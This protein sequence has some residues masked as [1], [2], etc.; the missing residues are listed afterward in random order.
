MIYIA[1]ENG[2]K[3]EIDYAAHTLYNL[4]DS[5]YH[6]EYYFKDNQLRKGSTALTEDDFLRII[7]DISGSSTIDFT[8]F[9]HDTRM[10][11]SIKNTD[12]SY[13]IGSRASPEVIENVLNDGLEYCYSNIM[14]NGKN[15][16][17]YYIPIMNSSAEAVGMIFAGKPLDSAADNALTMIICFLSICLGIMVISIIICSVY[18]RRIVYAL[19]DI[20]HYMEKISECDF[21]SELSSASLERSDEIG[22]IAQHA[23]KL[24]ISL[25]DLIERDPLTGL[26]NRRSC[27]RKMDE[28]R[29]NGTPFIVIMGDI[30]HFKKINDTY[31]HASGDAVLV[32]VSS[33]ISA[34]ASDAEGFAARWGGEEFLMIYP[35]MRL[36]DAHK[37]LEALLNDIRSER[38]SSDDSVFSITM[39]FGAAETA[40]GEALEETIKHADSLL[41][42]GK[43]S[44]RNMIVIDD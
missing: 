43:N 7:H 23:R 13:A 44:G 24:C 25:R 41:Y 11:T 36:D 19:Y 16:I 10:L 6:G 37:K 29:Q 30:D 21:S 2:V 15:Y 28:L 17:G 8:I 3:K 4:Y 33:I 20:R 27:R 9:W 22:D 42:K 5:N 35:Q 18:S 32:K 14:V 38:F 1:T 12:G 40:E 26:L 34:Q 39:T 31:G